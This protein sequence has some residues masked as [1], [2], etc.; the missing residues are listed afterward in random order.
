MSKRTIPA[1]DEAWDE[2]VLGN[3][4]AF[5]EVADE[6]LSDA[7]EEATGTQLISIRMQKV[8]I[9]DLKAIAARNGG[10]GYQTL[11]KQV[12]QRFV[13]CER[14]LLWNEFVSE[15]LRE[16]KHVVDEECKPKTV[17]PRERKAA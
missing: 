9:D 15:K 2:R 10:I 17:K 14:K 13:D 16:Q 12:L 6:A 4:E 7:A 5:V 8:M 3:D 11:V 1:T